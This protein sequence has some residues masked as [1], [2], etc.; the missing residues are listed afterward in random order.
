MT[1]KKW[2]I[3]LILTAALM[4]SGGIIVAIAATPGDSS[5][6]LVTLDYL[7][8]VFKPSLEATVKDAVASASASY[9]GTLDATMDDYLKKIDEKLTAV[10]FSGDITQN[11]AFIALMKEAIAEKVAGLT[12]K[13]TTESE[14]F[15]VVTL[16]AGQSIECRIGCEV[17]LRSGDMTAVCLGGGTL[18]DITAGS[19]ELANAGV[20][21]RNR[22]YLVT[23]DGDGAK[24][25]S[26]GAT[27]M[28]RGSYTVK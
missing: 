16:A 14:T 1:K 9:S 3:A 26:S 24:A 4:V 18:V 7:E 20:L 27:L 2:I 11:E 10:G 12:V 13:P 28:V 23:S 22:I 8:K 5:D 17:L 6:P 25:G 19:G 15:K 21:L